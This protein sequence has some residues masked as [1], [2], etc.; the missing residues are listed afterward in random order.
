M[1]GVFPIIYTAL[2]R[3]GMCVSCD[4]DVHWLYEG[5]CI[6]LCVGSGDGFSVDEHLFNYKALQEYILICC[7]HKDGG[8]LDKPDK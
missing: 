1:G 6:Y 7:Q 4:F 3:T 8:L 5:S 2:N